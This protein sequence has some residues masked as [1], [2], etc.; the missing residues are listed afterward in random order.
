MI[1]AMDI[2][3]G[4]AQAWHGL[5]VINP[6][7]SLEDNN[8]TKWELVSSPL[9][10][11]SAE[12]G[13]P[14]VNS[15]FQILRCSDHPEH[16]IGYP[17]NPNSF[18]PISNAAFLK[19]V[20]D[21]ISGTSHKVTSVGSVRNRGRVFVSIALNGMEAF[22]A[23]G[24]DF[25][26]FLNFGNGHDKSSVLWVNTSNICTVCDNTFSANLFSVESA[27]PSAGG[28][29]IK[30][31]VRHTKHSA[32]KLPALADLIDK[33]IGV[34]AEFR[35][36]M[37]KLAS[38][39]VDAPQPLFAGFL[40]RDIVDASKGLST[41][42]VNTSN[43]LVELFKSERQGNRGENMADAFSAITDYYSHE[44]SGGDN[45][46]R[47]IVSSEYGS[48]QN[49]KADFW[50]VCRNPDAVAEMTEHGGKLL[51]ATKN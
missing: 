19:L 25:S 31:R 1:E 45:K 23:A 41:R 40:G 15:G 12:D 37:D 21:S 50:K 43:R 11:A 38:V 48:G 13:S 47:Q 18:K 29:D 30:A 39:P 7:L 32:M 8:L 9:F 42:T 6:N 51:A 2:Q 20:R 4:L 17:F 33:A 46:L 26:A 34:Q 14:Y 44:S 16:I 5:T 49:A 27:N 3:E 28:D 36:A 22:K 24:R 10:Y 35:L